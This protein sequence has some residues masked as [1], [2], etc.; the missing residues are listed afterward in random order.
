MRS[1]AYRAERFLRAL[2]VW[3]VFVSAT[4]GGGAVGATPPPVVTVAAASDLRF[5][6]D[7]LLPRFERATGTR[8]VVTYGSSG[9][10]ATQIAQGAPFD[11]FFSAD[12]EY[13]Q[14]LAAQGRVLPGS[15]TLYAMGRLVVWTRAATKFDVSRGLSVVASQPVRF[16]AIANP[17]HAPYGRAAVEALRRAGLFEHVQE[18]LVYGEN[19]SQAFQ[20]ARTGNADIGI[21]ALSLAVPPSSRAEGRYTLV[22]AHLHR[23]LRQTFAVVR[24]RPNEAAARR[25]GDFV[26]S[27]PGRT[28][29]RA[30]GFSLPGERGP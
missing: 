30:F 5:A 21:L 12:E 15:S 3:V 29:L 19:V 28:V 16:V 17:A 27:P 26:M 22:S 20:L 18:R 1:P 9:I 25:I 23:P 6:F 14:Q 13:V 4:I 24:D 11:V 7:L 8:T 2:L 10:L